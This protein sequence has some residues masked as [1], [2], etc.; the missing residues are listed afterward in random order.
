MSNFVEY[1]SVD[2]HLW[3]PWTDIL[4]GHQVKTSAGSP[5][6][7]LQKSSDIIITAQRMFYISSHRW[8]LRQT[9]FSHCILPLSLLR[10][11]DFE[12]V[13][14]SRKNL[15]IDHKKFQPRCRQPHL[16]KPDGPAE[17]GG[18]YL[19]CSKSSKKSSDENQPALPGG[20][21]WLQPGKG[22]NSL[23]QQK[24]QAPVFFSWS[25]SQTA[26]KWWNIVWN[27][28]MEFRNGT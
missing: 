7:F 27:Y 9:R 8:I 26:R 16:H 10:S 15:K 4:H 13:G 28:V 23:L 6:F 12:G 24:H 25:R 20:G 3:G 1:V 17:Q 18:N 19:E 2:S 5:S 21:F 14:V 22:H 11:L